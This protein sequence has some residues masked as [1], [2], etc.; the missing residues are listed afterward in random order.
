MSNLKTLPITLLASVLALTACSE[1]GS[2]KV[3]D[4]INVTKVTEKPTDTKRAEVESAVEQDSTKTKP[5]TEDNTAVSTSTDD[6]E[7]SVQKINERLANSNDGMI[8]EIVDVT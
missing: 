4:D 1:E 2:K 5:I 3:S 8:A 6:S 7:N